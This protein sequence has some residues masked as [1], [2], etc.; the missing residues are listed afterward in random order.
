MKIFGGW[1]SRG[2]AFI[3]PE[4]LAEY[5]RCFCRAETIH[6]VCEDY[7]AAASIDLDHDDS[8]PRQVTSDASP[9]RTSALNSDSFDRAEPGHPRRQGRTL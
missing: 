2:I 1:G 5:E 9:V 4:A 7:R 8:R 6:A 3:E